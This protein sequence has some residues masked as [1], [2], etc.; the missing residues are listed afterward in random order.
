MDNERSYPI[1]P[2]GRWQPAPRHA[3]F[4]I[5]TIVIAV[6]MVWFTGMGQN[7]LAANL[8]FV[9]PRPFS[10]EVFSSLAV[11]WRRCRR[12]WPVARCGG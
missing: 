11:A 2:D 5:A 10:W 7:A 8:M 9:D 4:V 1:T 3:P 12:P 6:V